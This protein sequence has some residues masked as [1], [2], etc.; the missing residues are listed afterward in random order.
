MK[1]PAACNTMEAIKLPL[2]DIFCA[3]G[4]S[5]I[6]SATRCLAEK[7]KGKVPVFAAVP[8]P[9]SMPI[10]IEGMEE[11]METFL[12]DEIM[13]QKMLDHM[14][15]FFLAWAN[16]LFEA[17]ATG[18]IVTESMA[19][20]EIVPRSLFASRLLPHLKTVF[21]QVHAPIIFH[22]G[23]GSINHILDLLPGMPNLAGMTISSRD[24]LVEARGLI[25]PD[26]LLLGNLD[27]LSFPA[28]TK[29]EIYERSFA[30]LQKA[31]PAGHYILSNSAADI[32]LNTP[33]ENL[34]AMIEAGNACATCERSNS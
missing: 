31:A 6:L 20:A 29:G 5:M 12:F 10:L 3:K 14:G 11:W 15:T 28:A 25:G 21:A 16:A 33:P 13:A 17:G 27:N 4:L 18:I 9:C 22:H 1:H 23:G 34:I 30:C 32:P 26:L 2:P 8:G 19:A 7:Y 24:N